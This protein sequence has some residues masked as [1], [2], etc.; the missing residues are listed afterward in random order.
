[1]AEPVASRKVPLLVAALWLG[2]AASLAWITHE[3]LLGHVEHRLTAS[4]IRGDRVA[5]AILPAPTYPWPVELDLRLLEDGWPMGPRLEG[6][7]SVSET[8]GGAYAYPARAGS[9]LQ[10]YT[11]LYFTASDGTEPRR[12]GRQYTARYPRRALPATFALL[13][14]CWVIVPLAAIR[15]AKPLAASPPGRST[16]G[17]V[18]GAV[19]ASG[20]LYSLFALQAWLPPSNAPWLLAVA[21]AGALPFLASLP[22]PRAS[23][24]TWCLWCAGL[25]VWAL[26]TSL[27]GTSYASPGPALEF[28]AVSAGGVAIYLGARGSLER[29]WPSLILALFTLAAVASLARDAGFHL[30]DRLASLG[31]S[32]RWMEDIENPWTSKFLGHWLLVT[33]WCALAGFGLSSRSRRVDTALVSSLGIVAVWMNGTKSA[34]GALLLSI[35]VAGGAMLRPR[36]IRR[37]MV[38]TLALG[39]LSAP[40]LAAI[41]WRVHSRL[42]HLADGPLGALE[43]DVRGGV[44][45]FSRRLISLHPLDGWGFGASAELPGR[46]LSIADAL[47]VEPGGP[48]AVLSHH[49]TLAGGH[50]HNAAL[51]T[52]LDLGLVGALLVA[53]LLTAVGRSIAAVEPSR[54]THAALLG[55]LTV[56]AT[57]LVFNYPAWE[58]EVASILWMSAVLASS[59]LPRPQVGR[60]EIVRNGFVVLL[61]LGFGCAV[62]LQDGASRW[63]TAREL[64]TREPVLASD[65]S[66]LEVDDEVRELEYAES[67]DAGAE[68]VEGGP[69][70][71]PLLRGWA[72]DP[73]GAGAPDLVLVFVGSRLVGT[74]VPERPSPQAFAR[75]E[76]HDVRALV[77][78]FELPI[79]PD[80]LDLDAPVTLVVLRA[81]STLARELP[82][83]SAPE[84]LTAA[85]RENA[86]SPAGAA[87]TAAPRSAGRRESPVP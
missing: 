80:R 84:G 23:V 55:L 71:P 30:D 16:F 82:A 65:A 48:D 77:S 35:V 1:M 72:F 67:L 6:P 7:R 29:A 49:P 43:M 58:P 86:G 70:G 45:E 61:I 37:L 3:C 68:L 33:F 83:L 39:V 66:T 36:E 22:V 60:R 20:L 57:F 41:P 74:V 19:F 10:R 85:G 12:N 42:P 15:V 54:R 78:G 26:F 76:R 9:G 40:L 8:G 44:W 24:P 38:V 17:V 4:Q 32:G 62:L 64:R 52:W 63:L 2:M 50:P 53:G 27:A 51:L 14:A 47:G 11:A 81:G 69:G 25:A 5:L 18:Q 79:E 34:F 31:L 28:L 75:A 13:L 46:Q 59:V 87:R 73:S 21:V 56:N